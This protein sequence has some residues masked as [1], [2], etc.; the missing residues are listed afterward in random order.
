M[1]DARYL[2]L[3]APPAQTQSYSQHRSHF[4]SAVE[5]YASDTGHFTPRRYLE[6]DVSAVQQAVQG[7]K[8]LSVSPIVCWDVVR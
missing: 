4:F 6:R 7:N 1:A 2:L 5:Y 8:T 3:R